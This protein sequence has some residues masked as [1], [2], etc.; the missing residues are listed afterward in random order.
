MKK[1]TS[2]LTQLFFPLLDSHIH[3][4]RMASLP[5]C[6][7]PLRIN[8]LKSPLCNLRGL[9]SMAFANGGFLV[10]ISNRPLC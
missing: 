3:F 10:G 8:L 5:K 4:G 9:P 1:I 7:W 2:L 6:P